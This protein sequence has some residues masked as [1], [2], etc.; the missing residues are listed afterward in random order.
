MSDT[1]QLL[2]DAADAIAELDQRGTLHRSLGYARSL[3]NRLG[4]LVDGEQLEV[5]RNMGAEISYTDST[6]TTAT[7]TARR[8]APHGLMNARWRRMPSGS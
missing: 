7:G 1:T 3:V 8:A 5:E 4:D 2:E 6:R